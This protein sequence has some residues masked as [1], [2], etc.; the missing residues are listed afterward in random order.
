MIK[1]LLIDKLSQKA[2]ELLNEIPEFEIVARRGM[3]PERL[4]EEIKIYEAV[5]VSNTTVLN[6]NI[7]ESARNLRVIVRTGIGFDTI[8]VEF[9]RSRN[10]EVRDTPFAAAITVAEYTLAQMLGICRFIGPAYRSMKAHKWEKKIFSQGT[11]LSGKTAGIVG[12]GRIG[13]EVARREIELGM[14][15]LYYDCKEIETEL[16]AR[17]VS[18]DELLSQCDFI[19]VHLPLTEKTRDMFSRDAFAKMK[20][21]TVFVNVSSC[22]VVD[23]SALHLALDTDK[24]KAVAIDVVEEQKERLE[25]LGIIDHEKVFPAP[26]LGAATVEAQER[27]ELEAISILKDFFNV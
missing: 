18:L 20:K 8:D 25:K 7:L 3:T 10:I 13:R 24:L 9:A 5:V 19:S 2:V 4:K 22:G 27:A 11:E 26:H 15:V 12:M 21:D 23:M 16:K 14:N 1:V 6:R 17:Q